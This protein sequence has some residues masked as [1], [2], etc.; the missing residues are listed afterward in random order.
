MSKVVEESITS[1]TTTFLDTPAGEGLLEVYGTWGSTSAA[2]R[3]AGSDIN[4]TGLGAKTA[5]FSEVV[6]GGVKG[7]EIVT[8]GGSGISLTARWS[9]VNKARG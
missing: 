6:T 3:H 4:L 9:Q 7:L 8:T 2:V 5:D 1:A